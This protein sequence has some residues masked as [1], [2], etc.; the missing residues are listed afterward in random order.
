MDG[1]TLS[2][3]KIILNEKGN[4][5]HAL[6]KSEK[7]FSEFGE[8]YFSF[9]NYNEIKGWKKHQRMTLNL[10]VPMGKVQFFVFDDRANSATKDCF[11]TCTLSQT[12]YM[13]LTLFPGLWFAFKGVGESENLLMNIANIEHD[14]TESINQDLNA[15]QLP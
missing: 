13:R 4:I 5:M 7:E 6:K 11:F 9:V 10:F 2:P 3:L 12:N 1:V 8:A 14:P 15:F